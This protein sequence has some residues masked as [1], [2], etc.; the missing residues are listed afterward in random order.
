MS[1]PRR[2][3]RPTLLI[4]GCGDVGLRV[5]PLVRG[6]WRVVVLTST[7]ARVPALR[8]AG[9]VPLQGNLDEPATLGRLGGLPD[10]VLHLAPPPNQGRRDPRTA[11]LLAALARGGRVQT[12]VYASTTGVYGDRGGERID[13]TALPWPQTDRA[14]RRVDAEARVRHRGRAGGVRCAV[15]RIP[16]IYATDGEGGDPRERVR[17]GTLA[18]RAED[19]VY[20]NH[21]HADDLARA[22]VAALARARPQRVVNVCD[23]TELKMGDYLDLVA[24]LA[25]LPPVPRLSR[26]EA[27]E[28]LSPMTMSFMGES[29]R[30]GNQRL[31]REL[32]VALRHP[33]VAE[34]LGPAR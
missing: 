8:A 15:L 4:V 32:R 5:L 14:W 21:I 25:G 30:I 24:R 2:F 27:A 20:T 12:F 28:R 19:D 22:C 18:L 17:R 6:R 34:G 16:G 31:K 3:R 13:E 23:D 10:A 33:T 1:L 26:A 11:A 29:R 7:P 9:A